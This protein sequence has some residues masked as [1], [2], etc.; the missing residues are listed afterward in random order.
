MTSLT[1]RYHF[2]ASHRLHV[3]SLSERE[4]QA[5]FGK[6]N[7]PFGH[8]HDYVLSVTVTGDVDT[9]T[10]L[11]IETQALD[12]LVEDKVL[13][14]M[15]HRNLNVD[16]PQLAEVVPTTENIALVIADLL[17]EECRARFAAKTGVR[18]TKV[19]LQETERN[20]FEVLVGSRSHQD[21][22]RRLAPVRKESEEVHV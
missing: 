10:G 14:L 21:A 17:E 13:R 4:N 5:L 1:R 22:R 20:G 7:N 11:I 6:C 3:G 2:P 19:H 18:L 15:S 12:S 8:G 9:R 16:V